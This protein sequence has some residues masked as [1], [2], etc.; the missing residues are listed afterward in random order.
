MSSQGSRSSRRSTRLN[1]NEMTSPER[2]GSSLAKRKVTSTPQRSSPRSNPPVKTP[3]RSSSA[4]SKRSK[5]SVSHI[6]SP[7]ASSRNGLQ[8]N[9]QTVQNGSEMDSV[10]ASSQNSEVDRSMNVSLMSD[11]INLNAPLHYGSSEA[12]S[13]LHT[14][15]TNYKRRVD[16][17]T[18]SKFMRQI[19]VGSSLQGSELGREDSQATNTTEEPGAHLVI[20]GTDVSIA[21]CKRK[22]REFLR[23]RTLD[24]TRLEIDEINQAPASELLDAQPRTNTPYY[25]Q[26]LEEIS[27]IEDPFLNI[28][29]VHIKQFDVDLYRQM[30]SY[31]QE[32]IPA[33]DMAVNEIFQEMYPEQTLPHQINVRP[34]NVDKTSNLRSLNPEDI[35]QLITLSGMVI[36]CS[37]I[38]PEMNEAFFECSICNSTKVAEVDR[39]DY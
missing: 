39:Q 11:P 31:P 27:V 24:I 3:E 6:S 28:N 5:V 10:A 26:K 8:T 17:N 22:F 29:C 7:R 15:S 12:H 34:Y 35:N 21:H 36:R 2:S 18:D 32:V 16:L 4:L 19:N 20:W 9:G 1:A 23:C 14:G 37:N 38:I 13:G 30:V 33:F 25:I